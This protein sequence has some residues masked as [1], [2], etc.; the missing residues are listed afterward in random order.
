MTC[1]TRLG[2]AGGGG[3]VTVISSVLITNCFYVHAG[4]LQALAL[5]LYI[6]LGEK[7]KKCKQILKNKDIKKWIIG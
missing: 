4:L 5:L 1:L 7:Q 6:S 2:G 3:A